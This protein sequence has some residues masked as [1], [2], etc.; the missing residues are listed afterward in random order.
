MT[1]EEL[2]T[3]Y[4]EFGKK[5]AEFEEQSEYDIKQGQEHWYITIDGKIDIGI[6]GCVADRE[7]L[8]CGNIFLTELDAQRELARRKLEVKLLKMGGRKKFKPGVDNYSIFYDTAKP[9]LY[10]DYWKSNQSMNQ[11]YFDSNSQCQQ[12]IDI[13]KSE[14]LFVMGVTDSE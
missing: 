14:I 1:L 7:M 6:Y 9:V 13:Y 8:E 3:A 5:I 12:A 2:K 4:E 10:S 11:V